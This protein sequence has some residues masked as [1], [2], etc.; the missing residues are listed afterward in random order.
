MEGK[1]KNQIKVTL[2]EAALA[3]IIEKER[4]RD[5]ELTVND[6]Y[7]YDVIMR[8]AERTR[9]GEITFRVAR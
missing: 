3:D 9:E 5:I 1:R 2:T 4:V 8:A 7:S 6:Y